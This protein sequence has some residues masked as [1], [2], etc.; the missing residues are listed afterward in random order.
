MD[1][2]IYMYVYVIICKIE[3]LYIYKGQRNVLQV[4]VSNTE[5][6]IF[7][8]QHHHRSCICNSAQQNMSSLHKKCM[9]FSWTHLYT[10]LLTALLDYSY[11]RMGNFKLDIGIGCC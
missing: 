10:S 3:H 7:M 5:Y 1:I 8:H 2:Y 6:K 9:S 11:L 4:Q